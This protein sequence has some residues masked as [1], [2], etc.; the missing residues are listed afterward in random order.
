MEYLLWSVI[1]I[2]LVMLL[3]LLVKIRLL[4]KSAEEIAD[5]FLEKLDGHTNTLI[6]IS[7]RD[8]HM[9]RLADCINRSLRTLRSK[10]HRFEQGDQALKDA[11][12]NISHDLRTPLTSICGYLDLLEEET[13]YHSPAQSDKACDSAEN[14]SRYLA[15]IRNRTEVL[16]QLT[17][18]LFQYSVVTLTEQ[19][20]VLENVNINHV[21]EE[22]ISAQYAA[23]KSRRITPEISLPRQ[24]VIRLL[25]RRALSRIFENILQNALKYSDG[26]LEISLSEEGKL[27]FSNHASRLDEVQTQRLF[28]RMYTVE[29]ARKSTGLGLSIA[30]TLTEQM[31]GTI[32]AGY[33]AGILSIH[34]YFP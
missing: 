30:K 29:T 20:P 8:P 17:E 22:C 2:L 19:E 31:H 3:L 11:V 28:D 18:E 14:I 24:N 16:K 27:I 4:Q 6:D 12:T 34:I 23:F 32:L 7:S 1:G 5:G 10:R 26:D 21:L 15:V 25:D 9:R 33:S 13:R